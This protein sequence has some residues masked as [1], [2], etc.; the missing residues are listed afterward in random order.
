MNT[1]NITAKRKMIF[2]LVVLEFAVFVLIVRIF[3][4]QS[5]KSEE[6]QSLAYEQQTRDRLIKPNRG[7][8]YDRNM[9]GIAETETVASISVINAQVKEPEET[10]Q[11]LSDI[12]ELDY[13]YVFKKVSNKV[14]L[15]RIKTKVDKDIADEIRN[16]NLSGVVIDEDIK[17][18]YP[19]N[20]LASHVIGFVGSDNQGIIGLEAKYDEYLKGENGKILT[21]TDAGG[22]SIESGQSERIAPNDGYHLVTT[23]DLVVQQFAEQT[24]EKVL[25]AKDATRGAIILMNP[26]NGEIYAMANKPDFDLNEPFTINSSELEF[27]WD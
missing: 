18:V 4:I 6:L 22:R 26:Q 13:D 7:T 25:L 14:A 16:L 15:E 20:S 23:I 19:Y 3:I 17:R 5:V 2:V 21:E 8:I 24:L 27:I 12:L 9:I 11:I 1:L 10:S